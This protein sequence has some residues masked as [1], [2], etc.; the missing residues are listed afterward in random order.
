MKSKIYDLFRGTPIASVAT[1]VYART[2]PIHGTVAEYELGEDSI[3]IVC[4]DEQPSQLR[5]S[6]IFGERNMLEDLIQQVT[7]NDVVWDVGA[8]LGI[9]SAFLCRHAETVVSFEP[10]RARRA[11]LRENLRRNG[12]KPLIEPHFLGDGSGPSVEAD[13]L[14]LPEPTV[15][16]MDIEGG[17]LDALHGMTQLLKREDFRLIFIE[18][19]PSEADIN[20]G[21]T[22]DEYDEI[23]HILYESRF[24]VKDIEDRDGQ[25]F[26]RGKKTH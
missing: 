18:I 21:L 10:N 12:L 11:I 2:L 3:E 5:E 15:M 4:Q 22:E 8:H 19:H 24:S 17:E 20:N 14:E 6:I 9:Y 16:K 7:S 1:E 13:S 26:L 23:K 25:P